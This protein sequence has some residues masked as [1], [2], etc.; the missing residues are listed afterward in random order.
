V[1]NTGRYGD[2]NKVRVDSTP[3]IIAKKDLFM[4]TTL[5]DI[6]TSLE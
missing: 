6:N 2:A 4:R 1:H 3:V 5:K